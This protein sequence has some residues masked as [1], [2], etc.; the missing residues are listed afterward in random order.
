LHRGRLATTTY[1]QF[2]G[3]ERRCPPEDCGGVPG[4]YEFV[5]NIASK[6]TK[7]RK[8]TLDWYEGPYDPNEIDE[9]QV[10]VKLRRLSEGLISSR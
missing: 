3:G 4:Y 10:I 1:P 7:K 6:Q 5:G 9:E 2:L 8:S